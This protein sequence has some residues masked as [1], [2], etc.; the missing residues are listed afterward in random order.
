MLYNWAAENADK[1]RG[2][3]VRTRLGWPSPAVTMAL[4]VEVQ[5][6]LV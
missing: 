4:P 6:G 1:I 3:V 2:I 5:A